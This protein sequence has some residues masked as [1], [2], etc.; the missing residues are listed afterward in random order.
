M[1]TFQITALEE[2]ALGKTDSERQR[3]EEAM[4]NKQ[5]QKLV[6]RYK[7]NLHEIQLEMNTL[8]CQVLESS[9]LRVSLK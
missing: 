3:D 6:E 1:M 4:K 2:R 5:L 9:D 7:K 8:K